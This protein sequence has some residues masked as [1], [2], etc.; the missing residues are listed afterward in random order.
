[1]RRKKK[2]RP[3]P[4]LGFRYDEEQERMIALAIEESKAYMEGYGKGASPLPR[5]IDTTRY[6]QPQIQEER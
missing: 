6:C 5:G 1:M 4:T 2:H 3:A